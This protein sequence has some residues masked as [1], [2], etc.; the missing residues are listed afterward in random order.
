MAYTL[1][2]DQCAAELARH[3]DLQAGVCRKILELSR[4]QQKLVEERRESDLLVLLSEKQR[5]IGG[6][7]ALAKE[8]KIHREQWEASARAAASAE[9]HAKVEA[10]WNALRDILD[11][12]V[13][14]EDASRATLET[15]RGKV[16]EDIAKLQRGKIANKAYGGSKIPPPAAR[17][18]DK[19][20]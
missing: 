11:E 19:K 8:A 14:L 9:A 5:L 3:L 18:S 10:A 7:E 16:S 20:G 12:I 17:Y 1:T 6:H 4:Q 2:P 15:H 13:K